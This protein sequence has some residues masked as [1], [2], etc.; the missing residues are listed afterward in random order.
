MANIERLRNIEHR[1]ACTADDP[2]P[3]VC[4]LRRMTYAEH[5]ADQTENRSRLYASIRTLTLKE[6]PDEQQATEDALVAERYLAE[7]VGSHL[8]EVRNLTGVED[9]KAEIMQY[10]EIRLELADALRAAANLTDTGKKG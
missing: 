6:P 4:V 10:R 9:A 8:L 3:V 5:L 2:E 1:L 7:M